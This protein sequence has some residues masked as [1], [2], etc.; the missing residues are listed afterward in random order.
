MAANPH[1]IIVLNP[2]TLGVSLG[3][4]GTDCRPLGE[5]WPWGE[6]VRR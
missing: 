6:C 4:N 5:E 2:A 3:E 1:S